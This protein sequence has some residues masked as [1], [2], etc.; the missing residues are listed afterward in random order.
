MS[1]QENHGTVMTEKTY[2]GQSKL[3]RLPIPTLEDTMEK[4]PRVMEAVMPS[5]SERE[6]TK[7]VC[8]EFA[9]G[10]GPQLQAMLEKYA[11]DGVQSG[12]LGSYVEEFWNE[13]YL[14]PDCSVVLNLNP[15][16]VL[17]VRFLF[18]LYHTPYIS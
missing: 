13:A 18:I 2:R 11:E 8:D 10:P 17:E 5:A 7:R 15:F 3:P 16:F 1:P 4:F 14:A 12:R 9:K 6:E